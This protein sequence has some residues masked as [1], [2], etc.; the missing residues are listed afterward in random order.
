MDCTKMKHA[1]TR[2]GWATVP[3]LLML[4]VI[5]SITAGMASVSYTNV[6]SA[7]AMIGIAMAQSAAESGLSFGSIRLLHEVNRFVIDRGVIDSD[8][9][10]K[11]WKGTW[12]SADGNITVSPPLGYIVSAPTGSGVVYCLKDVFAQVDSHSIEV[13]TGDALLPRLSSSDSVLNV[14]PIPIDANEETYF[15]LQFG[16]IEHSTRILIT[17]VGYHNGI[18][19]TISMEFDLDKRID[20]ALVAM[21]RVMLG[22]N[23]HVEGPIGTRFGTDIGELNANFGVPLVMHSDFAGIDPVVLDGDIAAFAAAILAYDVD[24]DNRLRPSH[25]TESA[26]LGGALID[27]DGDQYVTEMDLFL[28]RY[29]IDG[30]IRVVYDSA[31]ASSAGHSGMT[32]EFTQDMQLANLIDT[33][34]SDRNMDGV[35]DSVDTELGWNDGIIDVRDRYAKIDGSVGF[36]VGITDWESASGG[37]WQEDVR[38]SIVPDF[39]SSASQFQLPNDRLAELTTS[40]FADSQTWFETESL[41]GIAFGDLASGQVQSNMV[42]GSGTYIPAGQSGWEGV[43]YEAN[44]AYDWYERSVYKD[45][46]FNNV[47]IPVGTNAVFDNCM[48]VGVTWVETTEDVD[49]PNWNFAGSMEP[50]GLGGYS[51]QFAGLTAE[52]NGVSYAST[53]ELSNNVRFHDCTFLGSIAADVPSEFTHWRNKIQVTGASRFFLDQDDPDVAAQSDG[54]VLQAILQSID[55]QDREQMARSS[56]LMPGWSVEIG[57]FQNDESVG[58]KL[59]GTIVSG[60]LDL[61]G[62]VDVH[63]AILSTYHPVEGE[64]ALFYGG[65]ADAFNTTLGYFGPEDGDEEG[66][67]DG[68]KTFSGYGRVS[69]RANPDAPMPDG[70]P[71]PITIVPDGSTYKEGT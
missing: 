52:T 10:E 27:Y 21:S 69:L 22:R 36:A 53:R 40:M 23:V 32:E 51:E 59:T 71:W 38:G 68:M 67:N 65:E 9:A 1:H 30:D 2:S 41:T 62:V 19:R 47:R 20:Y 7:Q 54:V 44:G 49:D 37:S 28:S 11:L 34:K 26:A 25:P 61:R 58:V 3:A 42:T 46:S 18:T 60:L 39:A 33:A 70:V 17:S 13:T 8:L 14:K 24:G 12:T 6:R 63:G 64:G 29:D 57:A 31:Q 55:P 56:V 16:L 66:I 15:R 48:F 43:P 45:M 50:D 35:M 4:T 5:A